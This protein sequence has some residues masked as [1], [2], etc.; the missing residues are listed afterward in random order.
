M[1]LF[2]LDFSHSRYVAPRVIRKYD[3]AYMAL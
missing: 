2:P 1:S 3:A